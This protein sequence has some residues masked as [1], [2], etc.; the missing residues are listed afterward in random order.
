M[1]EIYNAICRNMVGPRE[2]HT[3]W[4]RTEKKYHDTL[5]MWNLKRNNTNELIKQKQTHRLRVAGAERWGEEIN[6]WVWDGH[7]HI[8]IFKMDNQQGTTV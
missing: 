8:T 6:Y 7:V 3:E 5:Y 4:S 1:N 2:C